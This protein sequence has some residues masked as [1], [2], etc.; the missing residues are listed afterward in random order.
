M[1]NLQIAAKKRGEKIKQRN[2]ANP[3]I[4]HRAN[5]KRLNKRLEASITFDLY[6]QITDSDLERSFKRHLVKVRSQNAFTIIDNDFT[7]D[8]LMKKG[9]VPLAFQCQS[10]FDCN[11]AE[12]YI[13]IYDAADKLQCSPIQILQFCKDPTNGLY[14]TKD[15]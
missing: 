2:I 8:W 10:I 9:V 11:T 1:T 15:L 6:K 12:K 13:D 4:Q 14:F 3:N 5:L 7:E